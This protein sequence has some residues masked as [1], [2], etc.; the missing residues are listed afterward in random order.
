[1]YPISTQKT[2]IYPYNH[3]LRLQ[4]LN[5]NGLQ[6]PR[7]IKAMCL[8]LLTIAFQTQACSSTKVGIQTT[9]ERRNGTPATLNVFEMAAELAK[10]SL[11]L[12][13][14]IA[15]AIKTGPAFVDF[16]TTYSQEKTILHRAVDCEGRAAFFALFNKACLKY[17]S[18]GERIR[19]LLLKKAYRRPDDKLPYS[20]LTAAVM[21]KPKWFQLRRNDA[22]EKFEFVLRLAQPYLEIQDFHEIKRELRKTKK[23]PKEYD[24]LC[25]ILDRVCKESL[26]AR[27]IQQ[28]HQEASSPPTPPLPAQPLWRQGSKIVLPPSAKKKVLAQTKQ[29]SWDETMKELKQRVKPKFCE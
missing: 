14:D 16:Y 28:A 19:Q 6:Q 13:K 26:K 12:E 7:W 24:H 27:P 5:P 25:Q 22:F 4:E 23:Q 29:P 17:N 1:M 18:N 10:L 20:V 2:Y 9:Q 11:S 8:L 15:K 21:T 3:C